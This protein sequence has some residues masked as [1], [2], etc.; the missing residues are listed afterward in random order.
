MIILMDLSAFVFE[1]F[2]IFVSSVIQEAL[3]VN[4]YQYVTIA[5][6]VIS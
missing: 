5:I 4:T 3:L 2:P 1:H 6:K